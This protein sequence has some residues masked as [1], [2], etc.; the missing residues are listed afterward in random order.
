[1]YNNSYMEI[2]VEKI[3]EL[4]LPFKK[5]TLRGKIKRVILLILLISILFI[6]TPYIIYTYIIEANHWGLIISF[7]SL[8]LTA[9]FAS[10]MITKMR[11]ALDYD[12]ENRILE[13]SALKTKS[14]IFR[15]GMLSGITLLI[16]DMIF[17][18]DTVDGFGILFIV[19]ATI[20][21]FTVLIEITFLT[22][23]NRPLIESEQD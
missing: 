21:F 11:P 13:R 16:L 14:L 17:K 6:L 5:L 22:F 7:S 10:M 2:N 3:N 9:Y 18:A 4:A 15:F 19:G 1:M 8:S 23:S 12:M 20:L